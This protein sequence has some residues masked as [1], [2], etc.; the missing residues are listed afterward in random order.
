M[1][2]F[3]CNAE[4]ARYRVVD[5][6]YLLQ[7]SR[8]RRVYPPPPPSLGT[9]TTFAYGSGNDGRDVIRASRY[10]RRQ[11]ISLLFFF[12]FFKCFLTLDHGRLAQQQWQRPWR[13]AVHFI[14]RLLPIRPCAPWSTHLEVAV[15]RVHCLAISV[16]ACTA[17]TAGR[18]WLHATA[19][20][21]LF[22]PSLAARLSC[23]TTTVSC[24][25]CLRAPGSDTAL[26]AVEE[27]R[28]TL[29]VP[30]T[31]RSRSCLLACCFSVFAMRGVV[32]LRACGEGTTGSS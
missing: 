14:S 10:A 28:R 9:D 1:S 25:C 24:C 19:S 29:R 20:L 21:R 2:F 15:V 6:T 17:V 16:Y 32:F 8:S 23:P 18:L 31:C 22:A 3:R 7:N 12:S 26:A 5:Y 13:R 27:R 4:S 30:A 11:S